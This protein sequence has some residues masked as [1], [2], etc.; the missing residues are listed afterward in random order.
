MC[1]INVLMVFHTAALW[2][3]SHAPKIV[4]Y[5]I[6]CLNQGF[7]CGDL[8]AKYSLTHQTTGYAVNTSRVTWH[9]KLKNKLSVCIN[10]H[11]KAHWYFNNVMIFC[12]QQ[13]FN[14]NN[15]MRRYRHS[16]FICQYYCKTLY[17]LRQLSLC[18]AI[19]PSL[20]S[21]HRMFIP[22]IHCAASVPLL[23]FN[24]NSRLFPPGGVV[25]IKHLSS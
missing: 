21:Y 6:D 7:T 12:C 24:S 2:L 16:L 5:V 25:Q 1:C 10:R 8:S 22:W 11:R 3:L 17:S 4:F 18:T 13:W 23:C 9:W 20:I 19:W 14:R 15:S